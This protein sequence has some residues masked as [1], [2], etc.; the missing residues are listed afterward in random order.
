[1]TAY[2]VGMITGSVC[3]IMPL[4]YAMNVNECIAEIISKQPTF[5]P[6]RFAPYLPPRLLYVAAIIGAVVMILSALM[7]AL[8]G[9][10]RGSPRQPQPAPKPAAPMP[11]PQPE[12]AEEP[13]FDITP[14]A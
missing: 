9:L 8:T 12:P 11:A 7:A 4:I 5:D 10:R 6:G 14:E 1:M 3:L 13:P 2:I